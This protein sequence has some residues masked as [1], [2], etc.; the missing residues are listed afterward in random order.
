MMTLYGMGNER[1]LTYA[2]TDLQLFKMF[3]AILCLN[4]VEQP[5]KRH[6]CPFFLPLSRGNPRL[7]RGSFRPRGGRPPQRPLLDPR[8]G[9]LLEAG[10]G[11]AAE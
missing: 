7:R 4:A 5:F 2:N 1:F 11:R 3:I 8:L 9:L 10:M 6:Q